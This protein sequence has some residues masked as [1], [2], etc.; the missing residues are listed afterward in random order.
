[1]KLELCASHKEVGKARQVIDKLIGNAVAEIFLLGVAAQVRERQHRD[2]GNVGQPGGNPVELRIKVDQ[3]LFSA[4]MRG[5]MSI[6]FG[7]NRLSDFAGLPWGSLVALNSESSATT[8]YALVGP[9]RFA[10]SKSRY[11]YSPVIEPP[12]P[13][14]SKE[15][16]LRY[17]ARW[18]TAYGLDERSS[19]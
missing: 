9:A 10:T 16:L 15:T 4:V 3:K 17:A 7:S 2:R 8:K 1:V 11:W 6:P 12:G 5:R 14:V 18:R 13:G 19:R